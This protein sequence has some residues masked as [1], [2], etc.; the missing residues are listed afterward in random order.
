MRLQQNCL[1]VAVAVGAAA[2]GSPAFASSR[3]TF[4]QPTQTFG[5]GVF[6]PTAQDIIQ[7]LD[8]DPSVVAQVNILGAPEAL[9]VFPSLGVLAPEKGPDF[10]LLSTGIP[11]TTAEPGTDLGA[12]GEGGDS[13]D[14]EIVLNVPPGQGTVSF[15]HQFFSAEFPDFVGSNFNDTFLAS[16]QDADGV[17][18]IAEDSVNSSLFAGATH[19][20]LG[21]TQAHWRTDRGVSVRL[22]NPDQCCE[23]T[24]GML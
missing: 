24:K 21:K 1:L 8:L 4:V 9:K 23:T 6:P 2:F 11:G 22:R 7:A 19:A 20:A 14:V 18:A 15:S 12:G 3:G 5:P 10:L 16:V 13:V 17:D